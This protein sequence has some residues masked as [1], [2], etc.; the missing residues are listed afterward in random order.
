MASS[1]QRL[2]NHRRF[3]PLFHFGVVPVFVLNFL[4]SSYRLL[5]VPTVETGLSGLV[6]VATLALCLY[7]R[8]FPLTVQD[9]VIRLEMQ[10]RLRDVLPSDLRY[11]IGALS[12]GQLVALRFASDAELPELVRSVLVEEIRDRQSI[13]KRIK[14]WQEDRLRC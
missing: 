3:V 7:V 5:R 8:Q 14:H 10:L 2:A 6:A 13:K 4:W 1:P 9:R 12:R 11:R